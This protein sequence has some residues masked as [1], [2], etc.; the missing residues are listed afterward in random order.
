MS[1]DAGSGSP[2]PGH[3]PAH[4][5]AAAGKADATESLLARAAELWDGLRGTEPERLAASTG[6]TLEPGTGDSGVLL[7]PVWGR[8]AAVSYPGFAVTWRADGAGADPFTT[9]LLAY[10]FAASDGTPESGGR[11]AFSELQDGTFYAQAFQGYTGNELAKAFGNDG[12][13]FA[14]AAGALG[15][16]PE[17]LGD[18]AFGFRA[19]PLVPVAVA[20]WLG[21]EDFGPSYR[22]LFDA[23]VNHHLPTDVCAVLGSGLT[24]RL[25][26]ARPS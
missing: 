21:D 19:L 22:V 12:D 6:A 15:G 23:V 26:A 8:E 13:A 3:G 9:A 20:C 4:P 2:P 14:A 7:L 17:P 24:R 10:Y 11:I 25:I 5:A 1:K 18:L 16:L